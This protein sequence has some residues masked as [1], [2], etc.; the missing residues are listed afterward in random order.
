MKTGALNCAQATPSDCSKSSQN[1]RKRSNVPTLR[2]HE[3]NQTHEKRTDTEKT[4][5]FLEHSQDSQQ[6]ACVRIND[7][8]QNSVCVTENSKSLEYS[9]NS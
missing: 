8:Q 9:R 4:C 5:E 7:A 1:S 2:T 6:P 3:R